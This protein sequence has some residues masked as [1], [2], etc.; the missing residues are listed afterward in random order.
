MHII[1]E[2]RIYAIC[3]EELAEAVPVELAPEGYLTVGE[4]AAKHFDGRRTGTLPVAHQ[5][6]HT[7][8][9]DDVVD[10]GFEV[11]ERAPLNNGCRVELYVT[12]AEVE[13]QAQP[14]RSLLVMVG[15]IL[16][17]RRLPPQRLKLIIVVHV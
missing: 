13:P 5:F 2:G 4:A 3:I 6:Y 9:E 1:I 8:I 15:H 14:L 7:D 17:L 10:G 12:H 11:E 16:E